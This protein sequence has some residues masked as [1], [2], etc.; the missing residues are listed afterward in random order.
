MLISLWRRMRKSDPTSFRGNELPIGRHP[1]FRPQFEALE[2]RMVPARLTYGVLPL[3]GA[4]TISAALAPRPPQTKGIAASGALSYLQP[5]G[6]HLPGSS[7]NEMQVTVREN[8]PATVIDLG[9]VF[10]E[11]SGI[12]HED[13]LQMSLLGNTNPGLVKTDLS[14]GE[15]GLTYTPSKTGKATIIVGATDADGVSVR[16]DILVTV[17]PLPPANTGGPSSA[18]VTENASRRVRGVR[19]TL[20][21]SE[22]HQTRIGEGRSLGRS[23]HPHLTAVE[24]GHG[25]HRHERD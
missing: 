21:E 10:A 11:M 17:L 12:Q 22:Q 7:V 25:D 20:A 24:V 4:G 5:I 16:E 23:T 1:S 15:L 19:P 6:S 14:E 8:S 18:S 9:L 13:G 2:D 3:T